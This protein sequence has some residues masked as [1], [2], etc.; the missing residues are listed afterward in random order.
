MLMRDSG[1]RGR[2]ISK[3]VPARPAT[4]ATSRKASMEMTTELGQ[5]PAPRESANFAG[6]HLAAIAASLSEHGV[7]SRLTRL[8]GTPVLTIDEPADGPD[9]AAVAIDPDTSSDS[10]LR[11]DCT[12]IWTPASEDTPKATADTI[13]TVLNAIRAR[14][15]NTRAQD[16]EF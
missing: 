9:F 3:H 7:T 6:E 14:P 13:V 15:G 10:G 5:S 2:E 4:T 16:K 11:L 1:S 12:C 8:G